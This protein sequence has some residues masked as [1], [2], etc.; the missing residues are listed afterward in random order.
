[1]GTPIWLFRFPSVLSTAKR[2]CSTA[3]II[4]LAEVLPTL[5]VMPMT[6]SVSV[7]R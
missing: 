1:M 6:G 4:S 3:A 5:P 2:R 7:A